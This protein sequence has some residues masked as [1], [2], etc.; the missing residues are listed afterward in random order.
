MPRNDDH[1]AR[2]WQAANALPALDATGSLP[3]FISL[4]R[5]H[6]SWRADGTESFS[7][8]RTATGLLALIGVPETHTFRLRYAPHDDPAA[9]ALAA[10]LREAPDAEPGR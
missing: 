5:L 8:Y 9:Q 3:P 6:E 7:I 4:H 2:L 10:L 1:R